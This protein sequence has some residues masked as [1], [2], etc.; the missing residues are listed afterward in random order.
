MLSIIIPTLNEAT[1][2]EQALAAVRAIAPDAELIIADGGSSDETANLA[3]GLA[4]IV[5]SRRGRARQMNAGA[6]IA[7]GDV[8][9]FL[10]ADTRLPDDAQA[11][12]TEALADPRV[13]AGGFGLQFDQPGW[14]YSI[15]AWS[16]T[17]RSHVCQSFTGDQ[18]I[19]VRSKAFRALDGYADIPLME[20]VE[21]CR[22][23]RK[24]GRLRALTPPV[25]VS[26][27][28]HRRYGPVRV[29]L[30]GWLYQILYALGMPPFGLHRLYYGHPPKP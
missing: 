19:F 21:V 25:L 3:S 26:A 22:R 13:V 30:T 10:H 4:Q 17:L 23:L 8:L 20:D 14:F 12:I 6:A 5:P 24:V 7:T 29:L 9:L 16:T 27:R 28:R 2:I 15:M 11:A 18:A 1:Q